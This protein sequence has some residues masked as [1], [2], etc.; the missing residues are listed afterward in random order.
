MELIIVMVG[1]VI[2]GTIAL[3]I[4]RLGADI[5][6][7][8]VNRAAVVSANRRAIWRMVREISLQKDENYLQ[9]AS[10]SE[11]QLVTPR[12]D[13]LKYDLSSDKIRLTKNMDSANE[14]ATNVI[15]GQSSLS[16]K[17]SDRNS[18]TSFPLDSSARVSVKLIN[19]QIQ[20]ALRGDTLTLRSRISPQNL[21]YGYRMPYH[22]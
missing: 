16:Y 9:V 20:T 5:Y 4:F 6:G 10:G 11:V 22:D 17:D 3:N 7:D 13:T 18:L 8:V 1:I 12:D 14:L 2:I 21:H 15:S 19:V